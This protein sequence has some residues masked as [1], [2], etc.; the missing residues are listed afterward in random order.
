MATAKI[1]ARL[2][3]LP[4]VQDPGRRYPGL[5][6]QGDTLFILLKDLEEEAPES[7]ALEKVRDWVSMYEQMMAEVGIELPYFRG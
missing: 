7:Y 2:D 1:L 3:A 5:I 6:I 4:L